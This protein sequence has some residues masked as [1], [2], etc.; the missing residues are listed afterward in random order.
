MRVLLSYHS[1]DTKTAQALKARGNDVEV[2]FAPESLRAGSYWTPQLGEAIEQA[3]AFLLHLGEKTC[4][5]QLLE[6]YEAFDRHVTDEAFPLVPAMT[7]E[8]APRGPFLNMVHWIKTH[9]LTA[10]AQ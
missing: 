7:S 8:M 3:D 5:R 2:F 1:P 6:Y 10:P 4:R 9:A